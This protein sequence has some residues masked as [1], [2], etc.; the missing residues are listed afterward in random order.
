MADSFTQKQCIRW[1]AP[2]CTIF[3]ISA[4]FHKGRRNESWFS[5]RKTR[6]SQ[7]TMLDILH[8]GI[9]MTKKWI[10]P[11]QMR[12][13]LVWSRRKVKLTSMNSNNRIRNSH[14]NPSSD[15]LSMAILMES[16]QHV[17]AERMSGCGLVWDASSCTE[18]S[19][20]WDKMPQ[21]SAECHLNSCWGVM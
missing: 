20:K 2:A 15:G 11:K 12:F 21:L 9:R 13:N 8:Q 4:L 19:W 3:K 10:L 7:V 5:E 6:L 14:Q 17:R 18:I 16:R 1:R